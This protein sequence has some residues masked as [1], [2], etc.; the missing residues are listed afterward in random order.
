MFDKSVAQEERVM[1]VQGLEARLGILKRNAQNT[2]HPQEIRDAY[3]RELEK[4]T[5]L[6]FKVRATYLAQ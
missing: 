1:L 6:M 4:V 3:Q 2:S 5:K